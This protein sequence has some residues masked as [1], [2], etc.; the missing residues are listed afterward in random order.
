MNKKLNKSL[1]LV[2]IIALWVV[3]IV[4]SY[5]AYNLYQYNKLHPQKQYEWN[6]LGGPPEEFI[7]KKDMMQSTRLT[8]VLGILVAVIWEVLL[9]FNDPKKHFATYLINK[10]EPLMGKVDDKLEDE[11]ED[12]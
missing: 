3:L 9:Y 4:A 10:I 7:I 8:I 1:R 11:D 5:K 12:E 2:C 6:S